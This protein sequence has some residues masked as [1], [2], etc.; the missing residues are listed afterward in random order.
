MSPSAHK[1]EVNIPVPATVIRT[2][3]KKEKAVTCLKK[4][5]F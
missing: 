5:E 2:I 3:A 4:S 1:E